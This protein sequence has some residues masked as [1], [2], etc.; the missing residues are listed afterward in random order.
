MNRGFCRG[1][2][3]NIKAEISS[4]YKEPELHVC[5]NELSEEV[6]KIIGELHELYER[7]VAGTDEKGN[8]CML[9]PGEIVSFYAEGQ[10]VIA[11]GD[12]KRFKV[13]GKL[14]EYEEELKDNYFVRISKSEL[15]NIKKIKSLDMSIT[16]TIKIIMKNGYE[17]YVSRRNVAKI[18]E[19]IAVRKGGREYE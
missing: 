15:V 11:L 12:E 5:H 8:R 16:G 3:M 6:K 9:R 17:T 1:F 4:K 19:K 10:K 7:N 13:Q 2:V 14:Y 18:K